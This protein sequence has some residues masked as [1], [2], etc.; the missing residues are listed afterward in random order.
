MTKSLILIEGHH[1]KRFVLGKNIKPI[2]DVRNR[3]YRCD[4]KICWKDLQG[5]NC[6]VAYPIDSSQPLDRGDTI[7]NPDLTMCE[8]DLGKASHTKN[9]SMLGKLNDFDG[10]NILYIGVVIIMILAFLG[11]I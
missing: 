9:V 10:K 6:F 4:E 1:A 3:T 2:V 7:V 5:P 8:I 11:L